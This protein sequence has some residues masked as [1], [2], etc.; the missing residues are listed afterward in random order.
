MVDSPSFSLVENNKLL[1][2]LAYEFPD[3]DVNIAIVDYFIFW[4]SR[5][6]RNDGRCCGL[7]SLTSFKLRA[8]TPDN[9]QQH[10]QTEATSNKE[11]RWELMA[12]NVAP[13]LTPGA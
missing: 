1:L 4:R 10:V 7:K 2:S 9:M 13:V 8:T 5:N 11:Q 3:L 12:N 6:K